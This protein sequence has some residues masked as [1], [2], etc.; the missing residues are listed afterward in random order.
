MGAGGRGRP[1]QDAAVGHVWR[2][3][4]AQLAQVASGGDRNPTL[5]HLALIVNMCIQS[6]CHFRRFTG[7]LLLW[8]LQL[9]WGGDREVPTPGQGRLCRWVMSS[10]GGT[11]QGEEAEE[12]GRQPDITCPP[13]LR[14]A[15]GPGSSCLASTALIINHFL[16]GL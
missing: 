11:S 16:S 2:P 12:L 14:A 15:G 6:E 10:G 8:L 3:S 7:A 5:R 4:S 9:S 1:A 13:L